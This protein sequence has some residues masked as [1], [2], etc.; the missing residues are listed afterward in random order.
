[1]TIEDIVTS[2]KDKCNEVLTKLDKL[3]NEVIEMRVDIDWIKKVLYVVLAGLCGTIG[4]NA[5]GVI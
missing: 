5:G 1:M 2:F 3:E 4:L